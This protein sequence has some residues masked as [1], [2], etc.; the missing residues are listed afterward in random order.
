MP[1]PSVFISST[2]Y[3]LKYIRDDLDAFIKSYGFEP[4]L[5]ER[6]QITYDH[7]K[8]IDCSCYRAVHSCQMLILI[9][10]GRYGSEASEQR[11]KPDDALFERYTSISR[12]EYQTAIRENTPSYI[13]IDKKVY[14]EYF[15]YKKNKSLENIKYA[16][17]DSVNVFRFIE[18]IHNQLENNIIREFESFD[19]I[20]DWL[21]TQWAGLFYKFLTTE[22]ETN[23]IASLSE[24]ISD[25]G[26]ITD[27]LKIY[28]ENILIASNK[29]EAK[30]VIN[31]E[32]ERLNKLKSSKQKKRIMGSPM[33]K[34]MRQH[35]ELDNEDIFDI[36]CKSDNLKEFMEKL[37][38]DRMEMNYIMSHSTSETAFKEYK[39]IIQTCEEKT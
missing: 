2:Y 3:D 14:S 22:K 9:I 26:D 36:F 10:G 1:K 5:F 31:E 24:K 17:V 7:D 34:Y 39:E 33:M 13:F 28:L 25:L 38:I 35:T 29:S 23:E 4:I 18:E 16:H 19:E 30:K 20:R 8:P 32:E 37:S 27:T 6:G 12:E 21:R 11:L 15:T